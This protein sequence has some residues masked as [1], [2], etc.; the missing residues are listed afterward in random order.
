VHR[1]MLE[2][3]LVQRTRCGAVRDAH[4]LGLGELLPDRYDTFPDVVVVV[5]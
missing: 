5:S 3:I 4:G 1:L 2:H